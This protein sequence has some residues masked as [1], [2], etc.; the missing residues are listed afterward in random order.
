MKTLSKKELMNVN[1]GEITRDQMEDA[2]AIA[3]LTIGIA[4]FLAAGGGFIATG[5][6]VVAVAGA[7]ME[8]GDEKDS[9]N[10]HPPAGNGGTIQ[11]FTN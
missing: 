6:L 5:G 9:S 7:L 8:A 11:P 4:S 1:G 3:G 10:Y 2:L